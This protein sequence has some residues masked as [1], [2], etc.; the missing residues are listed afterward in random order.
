MIYIIHSHLVFLIKIILDVPLESCCPDWIQNLI[1]EVFL[2]HVG[3][4][5]CPWLISW[6]IRWLIKY[7]ALSSLLSSRLFYGWQLC[8]RLNSNIEFLFKPIRLWKLNGQFSTKKTSLQVCQ[9]LN[10]RRIF[11]SVGWSIG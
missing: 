11:R 9:H 5:I 4:F 3:Y 8:R 7:C 10:I 1:Q 2:M 6:T